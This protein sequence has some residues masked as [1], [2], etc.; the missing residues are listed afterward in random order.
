MYFFSWVAI[1]AYSIRHHTHK[2]WPS[3]QKV[4]VDSFCADKLFGFFFGT[5]QSWVIRNPNVWRYMNLLL[6]F[7]K[8]LVKFSWCFRVCLHNNKRAK[9]IKKIFPTGSEKKALFHFI[10]LYFSVFFCITLALCRHLEQQQK[11]YETFSRKEIPNE[12]QMESLE[13][14]FW[15]N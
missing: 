12:F 14:N 15:I 1:F 8:Y 11:P 10:F 4:L 7:S 3:L 6:W 5:F 2:T 9:A 13:Y